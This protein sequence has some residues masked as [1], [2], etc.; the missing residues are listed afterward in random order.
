MN[1]I[2]RKS[3]F[4]NILNFCAIG[5]I[6]TKCGGIIKNG[7]FYRSAS[8]ERLSIK[9]KHRLKE[10]NIRTIIDI[11]NHN[12]RFIHS[13]SKLTNIE[14]FCIPYFDID[15]DNLLYK[16]HDD[17]CASNYDLMKT[18][19]LYDY[20][21]TPFDNIAIRMVLLKLFEL[22]Q[23]G[24]LFLCSDGIHRTG[25][26]V[27]L[28]LLLLN[29]PRQ[30]VV[31]HYLTLSDLSYEFY[32]TYYKGYPFSEEQINEIS[33]IYRVKSEYIN[34]LLDSILSKYDTFDN[35]FIEEYS[36]SMNQIKVL[37]DF[38]IEY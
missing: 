10:L 36:L 18:T 27:S 7:Y 33:N 14:V 17:I 26:V 23:N 13:I 21:L 8:L 1:N 4:K 22:S 31:E 24:I 32:A 25:I 15:R 16:I 35:F 29:V 19:M 12:E 34:A 30:E 2:Y 3:Y 9:D 5:N 37:R 6:R 11:R 20:Q 38:Y 28:L